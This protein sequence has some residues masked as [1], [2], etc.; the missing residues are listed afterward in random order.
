MKIIY[1]I[2][3]TYRPAG[4]ERVLS[5]KASALRE[6]G[7]EI[8]IVTTDQRGQKPA[9]NLGEFRQIDLGINYELTN[10]AG[11][12]KKTLAY[13][14]K[15]FK[16]R[17][18]LTRV[19][20]AEKADIVVCMFDHDAPFAW[21]V[22]D[23]SKKVLEAHF[24]R[25]KKLQYN[26][27]GLWA[28]A[29]RIRGNF[30]V[31]TASKYDTFVVL[32][33]EDKKYWEED[34]KKKGLSSNIVNIPNPRTF[35]PEDFPDCKKEKIIMAAGRYTYQKGF[36]HLVLAWSRIAP[37]YP[38]WKLRIAGDGEDF[39]S[40]KKMIE[41]LLLTDSVI[42]GKTD[43]VK[44]LFATS[45]IYAMTSRYEGLPMVLLEAQAASLPIVS[46]TCKCGPLDIVEDGVSGI[47]VKEGDIDSFAHAL[48]TLIDDEALRHKMG[49][50][51]FANS[52][53]FD[54]SAIM[55][56]WTALFDE[57]K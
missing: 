10:G 38:D 2:A 52:A 49:A 26:R 11:I 8:V 27:T 14:L 21:A 15:Q 47:L 33:K 55:D 48:E 41:D 54:R 43:D 46:Y 16:H 53:R 13:P 1:L 45:S 25:Y 36:D 24:S 57:L 7:H 56:R 51:A 32:T 31:V 5:L 34:Y 3:G 19:L 4:M 9:F 22:K 18:L 23:G 30:D 50:A 29:D 28:L 17:R 12:L 20:M 40:L 42:L 44:K 39:E 35:N 6:M 37:K